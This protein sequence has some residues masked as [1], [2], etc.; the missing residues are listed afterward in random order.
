MT[1]LTGKQRACLRAQ[2]NGLG[3]IL[4]VGKEGL[5][6]NLIKQAGDALTARE[7]IKGCILETAPLTARE[8]AEKLSAATGSLTV[9]VIGRR[10]VLYRENPDLPADK[11]RLPRERAI[12]TRARKP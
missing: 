1:A 3:A 6:H 8:A 2:A 7:L 12:D 9:Q 10:F 4:H 5:S 11:R